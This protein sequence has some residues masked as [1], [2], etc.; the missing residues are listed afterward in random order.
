MTF[1][2]LLPS[3]TPAHHKGRLPNVQ[4]FLFFVDPEGAYL[5]NNI[6]S[7]WLGI[8]GIQY[9]TFCSLESYFGA[10]PNSSSQPNSCGFPGSPH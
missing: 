4:A 5:G 8:K 6:V 1:P 9:K 3:P 2:L 10:I 7:T